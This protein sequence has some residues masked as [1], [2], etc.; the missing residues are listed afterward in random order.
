MNKK[1]L[2]LFLVIFALMFFA[3]MALMLFADRTLY[4]APIIG[5][6]GMIWALL[7]LRGVTRIAGITIG[8]ND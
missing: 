8:R 6:A 7:R 3:S 2:Y 5:L 4:L 1:P